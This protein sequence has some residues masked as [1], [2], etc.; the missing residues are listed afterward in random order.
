MCITP[1]AARGLC[2]LILCNNTWYTCLLLRT[3]SHPWITCPRHQVIV[4]RAIT[5]KQQW[6]A[7]SPSLLCT[8]LTAA[9]VATTSEFSCRNLFLP[10]LA[11]IACVKL[12]NMCVQHTYFILSAVMTSFF[13]IFFFFT[14]LQIH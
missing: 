9:T 2:S 5:C 4:P 3:V 11:L 6:M 7:V 13:V 1:L 14:G 12:Y 8:G 10:Q